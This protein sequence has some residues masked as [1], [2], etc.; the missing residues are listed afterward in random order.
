[1]NRAFGKEGEP[2]SHFVNILNHGDDALI[3]RIH[4]IRSAQEMIHFQTFIW[5]NDEASF[6]VLREMLLAARRGVK[7]RI[8]V[9]QLGLP[10]KG[11]IAEFVAVAHANMEVKIYNPTHEKIKT[12]M[13]DL[14]RAIVFKA[15]RFNQRMHNKVLIVDNRIAITGGRNIQNKYFDLDPKYTFKDRDVLVVG[16]VVGDMI[17]SCLEYWNY[18]WSIPLHRLVDVKRRIIRIDSDNPL[19]ELIESPVNPRLADDDQKASD[20][21]YIHQ[22][23]VSA[24]LEVEGRVIFFGDHPA[25]KDEDEDR[26]LDSTIIG[27]E[28]KLLQ[29]SESLVMQTPYLIFSRRALRDF[30]AVRKEHPDFRFIAVTN[31]LGA[32][33]HIHV[34]AVALKYRHRLVKQL[35]FQVHELKPVPGDVRQMIRRYDTLIAEKKGWEEVPEEMELVQTPGPRVGTHAKCFVL[36]DRI[37]WIGSHNLDPRGENINTEAVLVIWDEDVALA[38]K[39]QIMH[40]AEPQNSWLMAKRRKAPIIGVFGGLLETI[41][42]A[43]PVLDIWPFYYTTSYEL[44]PEKAP[45][46]PDHSDFHDHYKAVGPFPGVHLSRRAI[47]SRLATAI[48]GWA[49]PLM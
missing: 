45:V 23:F 40:D 28:R 31:S 26:Q 41:S 49:A 8:I 13:P 36:D 7:V 37:A 16:P 1:M 42:R 27:L 20:H 35:K 9:D 25:K 10:G 38:L 15:R 43:L 14:A 21:D 32:A 11:E 48:G 47:W 2:T 5:G 24:A 39:E 17:E 19:K 12:S 4:L 3:A 29:A 33:D 6:Y 30:K 44:R 46:P 18:E 22:T 34:Y